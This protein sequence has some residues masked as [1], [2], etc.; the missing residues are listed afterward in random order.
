MKRKVL[1]FLPLALWAALI[2][3]LSHRTDL[4]QKPELPGFD[5]LA[6]AAEYALLAF[7]L[8]R[9]LVRGLDVAPRKAA[10][11]ALCLGAA[12]GATDELH[13]RFVPGRDSSVYDLAADVVGAG[14]G[15]AAWLAFLRVRRPA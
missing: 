15:A 1:A 14:L 9:A 6:H 12:F 13:Q 10:V 2:F 5:K 8:A 4:P 7:L 3:A 11:L